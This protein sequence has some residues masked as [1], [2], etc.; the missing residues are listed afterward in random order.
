MRQHHRFPFPGS[1]NPRAVVLW[2]DDH[3]HVRIAENLDG[4]SEVHLRW[5]A[6]E[7]ADCECDDPHALARRLANRVSD[8]ALSLR[9]PIDISAFERDL[10]EWLMEHRRAAALLDQED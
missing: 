3:R 4:F 10:D 6:A 7:L 2:L 8:V 5:D 1:D 9:S